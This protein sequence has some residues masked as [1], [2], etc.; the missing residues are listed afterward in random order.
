MTTSATILSPDTGEERATSS[1]PLWSCAGLLR[2]SLRR[3]G[4]ALVDPTTCNAYWIGAT[5]PA[6]WGVRN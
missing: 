3:L 5:H 6:M 2:G 1:N 4:A